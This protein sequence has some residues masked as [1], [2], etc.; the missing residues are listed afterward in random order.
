MGKCTFNE[1]WL[2]NSKYDWLKPVK[3]YLSEARCILCK[4]VFK[5][6]TMGIKA[7]ESHMKCDRHK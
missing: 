3:E 2:K 7:L 4:K 5:L 1:T 6:G